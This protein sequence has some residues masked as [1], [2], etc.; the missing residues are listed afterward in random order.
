MASQVFDGEAVQGALRVYLA[1][2]DALQTATQD[3]A[4]LELS[5]AKVMAGLNLR[6]A[7]V[8]TGWTAPTTQRTTT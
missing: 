2:C 5:D 3:T 7:L 1:A 6:K 4:F 8:D